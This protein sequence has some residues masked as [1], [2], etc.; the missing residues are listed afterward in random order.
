VFV[1]LFYLRELVR[2]GTGHSRRLPV[3]VS[4]H[5]GEVL[6]K[7]TPAGNGSRSIRRLGY[8]PTDC[9][10]LGSN[11]ASSASSLSGS[12]PTD[13]PLAPPPVRGRPLAKPS[14]EILAPR[15]LAV[16]GPSWEPGRSAN[17]TVDGANTFDQLSVG[18]DHDDAAV[19]LGD[20]DDGVVALTRRVY[21][22][23]A[24]GVALVSALSSLALKH[25]DHGWLQ[26]PVAHAST[27]LFGE[28]SCSTGPVSPPAS[29]PGPNWR[30][31]RRASATASHR[32]RTPGGGPRTGGRDSHRPV[33]LRAS[34]HWEAGGRQW[35]V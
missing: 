27:H 24:V 15:Q 28:A 18:G 12:S 11:R 23:H 16:L 13:V 33:T 9:R 34:R 8:G 1:D 4:G 19:G 26:P 25:E 35:A 20:G 21:D 6:R 10:T 32:S 17:V 31:R 7:P 2:P 30:H 29:R 3:A 22:L 5:R 14:D